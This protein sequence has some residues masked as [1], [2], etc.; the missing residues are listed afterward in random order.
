MDLDEI[1][2]KMKIEETKKQEAIDEKKKMISYSIYEKIYIPIKEL[3]DDFNK[4]YASGKI[5]LSI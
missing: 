2:R 1:N 3:I 4:R 5:V